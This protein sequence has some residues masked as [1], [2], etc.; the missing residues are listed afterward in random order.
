MD[1][2]ETAATLPD[3]NSRRR[4]VGEV[5]EALAGALLPVGHIFAAR[6]DRVA[7]EA[8]PGVAPIEAGDSFPPED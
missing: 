3:G 5:G 1:K 4:F 8:G 6:N 7:R 2:D